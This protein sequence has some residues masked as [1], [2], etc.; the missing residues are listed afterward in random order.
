MDERELFHP[1]LDPVSRDHVRAL[2]IFKEQSIVPGNKGR[3]YVCR[4]LIRKIHSVEPRRCRVPIL[5]LDPKRER[6]HGAID[7]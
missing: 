1:A 6:A 4:R 5:R 3:N 7:P 2:S